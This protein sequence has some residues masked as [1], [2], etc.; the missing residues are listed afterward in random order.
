[1]LSRKGGSLS[2]SAASPVIQ[3]V[4]RVQPYLLTDDSLPSPVRVMSNLLETTP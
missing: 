3:E 2:R 4:R 1:M